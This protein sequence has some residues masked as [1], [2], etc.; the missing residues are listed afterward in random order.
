VV[1]NNGLALL[2]LSTPA[3]DAAG[4]MEVLVDVL[5]EAEILRG[6]DARGSETDEERTEH[7]L[8]LR[9]QAFEWA[10]RRHVRPPNPM[11]VLVDLVGH[12]L[13][14]RDL[15]PDAVVGVVGPG[16]VRVHFTTRVDAYVLLAAREAVLARLPAATV[17]VTGRS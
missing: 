5:L 15:P 16:L 8:A 9:R 14:E 7:E 13:A 10:R 3:L 11:H 4:A 2:A 12:A 17:E 1:E 6:E